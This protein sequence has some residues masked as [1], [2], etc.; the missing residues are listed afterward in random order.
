MCVRDDTVISG[1]RVN[2][3]FCI[4]YCVDSRHKHSGPLVVV[5]VVV[6]VV[7]AVV[8]VVACPR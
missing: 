6:V 3:V 7:V 4:L 8:I 2:K 5:V 1:N